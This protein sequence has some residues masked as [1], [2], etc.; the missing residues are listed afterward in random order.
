MKMSDILRSL[1]DKLDAT[2]NN[3]DSAPVND[4]SGSRSNPVMVAPQQQELELA[5][6]KLG[7]ESPVIDTLTQP[8]N[9]GAE[10]GGDTLKRIVH[11]SK[12]Q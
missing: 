8:D 11:L 3:T 12:A 5:K 1:A 6:A 9:I 4:Q 10:D 2:D 7:K